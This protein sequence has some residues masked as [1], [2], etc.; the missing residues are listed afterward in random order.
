MN[1]GARRCVD[2]RMNE[3]EISRIFG[4]GFEPVAGTAKAKTVTPAIHVGHDACAADTLDVVRQQDLQVT[5]GGFLEIVTAGIPV[6]AAATLAIHAN[7]VAG[8]VQE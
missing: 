3:K 7:D 2:K 1:V 5:H 6:E 8:L 4:I